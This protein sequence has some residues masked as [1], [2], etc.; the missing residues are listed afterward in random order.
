[1]KELKNDESIATKEADKREAVVIMD[2]VHYECIIYKQIED[3]NTYNKVDPSCDN[4]AMR[5]NK[6]LTNKVSTE[7]W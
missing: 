1:M 5:E 6:A 3:K 4:K 7:K 2:S